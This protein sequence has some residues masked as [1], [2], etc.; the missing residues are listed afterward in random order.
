MKGRLWL[1]DHLTLLAQEDFAMSMELKMAGKR[2]AYL[3]ETLA[4]GA[5]PEKL[6]ETFQQRSRWAK[7]HW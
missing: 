5:S 4:E 2:G 7:G 1:S 3:A 6:R